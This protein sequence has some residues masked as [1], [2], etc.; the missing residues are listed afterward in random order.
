MVDNWNTR[1]EYSLSSMNSL[2]RCRSHVFEISSGDIL[3]TAI[4]FSPVL[5]GCVWYF[6]LFGCVWCL[7]FVRVCLVCAWTFFWVPIQVAVVTS[8]CMSFI[9]PTL[10]FC[11]GDSC[12]HVHRPRALQPVHGEPRIVVF[13]S[14]L[15]HYVLTNSNK[16]GIPHHTFN[17]L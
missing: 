2:I 13:G 15:K 6:F 14:Q 8:L 1:F 11:S 4:V 10:Y 5:F 16:T 7:F 17:A 12:A 3:L 9:C